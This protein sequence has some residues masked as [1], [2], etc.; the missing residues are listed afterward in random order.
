MAPYT[1]VKDHRTG[2]EKGNVEG[3]LNGSIDEFIHEFLMRRATGRLD[4][5]A[6]IA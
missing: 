3:V 2:L 1:L 4:R 6:G 5:D